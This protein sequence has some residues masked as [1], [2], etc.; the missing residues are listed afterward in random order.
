MS[1]IR[2]GPHH[3]PAIGVNNL[4]IN[5]VTVKVAEPDSQVGPT[6]L[7]AF[8]IFPLKRDIAHSGASHAFDDE[9]A[10]PIRVGFQAW[11]AVTKL[12]FDMSLPQIEWLM[13]MTVGGNNKI[14]L[15]G[16]GRVCVTFAGYHKRLPPY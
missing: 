5:A 8:E 12:G 14:F 10:F 16:R 6:T 2:G 9:P 3:Q 13:N 1:G 15:L 4:G 11:N 7:G